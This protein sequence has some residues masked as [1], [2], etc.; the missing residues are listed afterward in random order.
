MV[1]GETLLRLREFFHVQLGYWTERANLGLLL[2]ERIRRFYRR[3]KGPG[4][5]EE[6]WSDFVYRRAAWI[7]PLLAGIVH[8]D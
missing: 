2:I 5:L 4:G 1:I 3:F 8:P 6:T 7:V